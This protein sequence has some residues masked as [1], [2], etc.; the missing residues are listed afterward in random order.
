ML[1]RGQIKHVKEQLRDE[2]RWPL[3]FAALADSGRFRMFRLLTERNDL[4]VTDV[5]NVLGVSVPAASQQLKLLEMTGLV[6]RQRVG[7]MIC[8]EMKK[9]DPIVKS[10]I[11]LLK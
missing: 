10:I 1:T 4:C 3:I 7:Q 2:T 8:Y 5:A 9:R 11:T 6:K